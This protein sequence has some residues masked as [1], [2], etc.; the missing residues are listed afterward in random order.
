MCYPMR[1]SILPPIHFATDNLSAVC[2]SIN[3][4]GGL[5]RPRIYPLYHLIEG[6]FGCSKHILSKRAWGLQRLRPSVMDK[7]IL[8][9]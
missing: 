6:R 8:R 4:V 2:Q 9:Q 5:I 7:Q 1:S 3:L